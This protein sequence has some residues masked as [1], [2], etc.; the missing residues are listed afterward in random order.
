DPP[1]GLGYLHPLSETLSQVGWLN[2][3]ALVYMESESSLNDLTLSPN[4]TVIKEKTAGN[5]CY[6]LVRVR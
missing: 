1:F 3:N 6:R 5:V 2:P 4:W